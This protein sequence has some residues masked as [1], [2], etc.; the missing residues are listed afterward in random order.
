MYIG[1]KITRTGFPTTPPLYKLIKDSANRD[2]LKMDDAVQIVAT[3]STYRQT[4][5]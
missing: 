2:N 3:R 4:D 5:P 1:E